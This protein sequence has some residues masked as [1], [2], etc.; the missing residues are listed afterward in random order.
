MRKLLLAATMAALPIVAHA[1]PLFTLGDDVTITATNSPDS[2]TAVVPFTPGVYSVDNSAASVSIAIVPDPSTSQSE[3]AVFTITA[4]SG[5][6]SQSNASWSFNITGIPAAVPSNLIGNATQFL[7]GS[8][9]LA[10]TGT[11]SGIFG[12]TLMT[13]PVPGGT[14]QAEGNVGYVDPLGSGPLAEL[15]SSI[16]PF[17]ALQFFGIASGD[18]TGFTEALQF[19]PETPAPEPASIAILGIGL[20]G[21]RMVR[22]RR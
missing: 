11:G 17:G 15:G 16:D 21:F 19:A 9:V 5:S 18:V 14:G 20:L 12:Q 22:R 10:Q 13:D 7:S 3:W 1:D 2:F 6:L 4:A 8:T